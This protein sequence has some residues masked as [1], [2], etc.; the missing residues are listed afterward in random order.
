[1]SVYEIVCVWKR[2]QSKHT[3]FYWYNDMVVC[4]CVCVCVRTRARAQVYVHMYV[5]LV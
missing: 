5:C 4:V 2:E 1:M 3:L